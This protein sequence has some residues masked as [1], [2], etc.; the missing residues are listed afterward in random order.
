MEL[1]NE[2]RMWDSPEEKRLLEILR[3]PVL[4]R[5]L[6]EEECAVGSRGG[7]RSLVERWDDTVE[8]WHRR[9]LR[10]KT[11]PLFR[12]VIHELLSTAQ[13][14]THKWDKDKRQRS[15]IGGTTFPSAKDDST[16]HAW[17]WHE[18]ND[19]YG[20]QRIRDLALLALVTFS[21]GRL[22]AKQD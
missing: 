10:A 7:S 18:V 6:N 17:F 8:K 11:R 20:W 13:R 16:F 9:F 22:A 1:S 4:W 14:R 19:P 3:Y 12:A 5:L 21:D 2:E 15:R